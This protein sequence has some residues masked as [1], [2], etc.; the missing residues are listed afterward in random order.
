M[1]LE[2]SEVERIITDVGRRDNERFA[3]E[4]CGG[5]D[6]RKGIRISERV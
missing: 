6:A 1:N 4:A 3:L 2:D 5:L